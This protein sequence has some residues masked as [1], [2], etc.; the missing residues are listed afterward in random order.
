MTRPTWIERTHSGRSR[1]M[2]AAAFG[3]VAAVIAAFFAPWQMTVLIGW[4]VAAIV[5]LAT[6]WGSVVRFSAGQTRAFA[7]AE[8][9]TR[10]GTQL[11]LL[12]AAVVSLLGVAAAFLKGNRSSPALDAFL[13]GMGIFT[14][15]C[16][17]AL[18]HTVFALRYAH[19]YYRTD[20]AAGIDFKMG[21]VEPDYRDFAYTAF[22]VGMTF[23]VSDTDVTTQEMRRAVLRHALLSFL[24]GAVIL[25][26]TVNVIAGL[27][28]SH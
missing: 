22:T 14:I 6:V 7:T 5:M 25:A 12:G 23:Q 17:W 15:A 24:F 18:V 20:P 9:N 11:T 13:E 28:N 16:S 3:V 10:A 2:L 26:T 4:D 21:T 19:L 1:V 27:L 8:D